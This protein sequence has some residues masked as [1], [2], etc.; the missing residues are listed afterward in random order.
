MDPRD[1]E[2]KRKKDRERQALLDRAYDRVV[3]SRLDKLTK[4]TE[5]TGR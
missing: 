1:R 2:A 3:G 4:K 5:T